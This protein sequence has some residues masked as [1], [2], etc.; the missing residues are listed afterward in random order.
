MNVKTLDSAPLMVFG[1]FSVMGC[2]IAL[3]DTIHS[4]SE[5]KFKFKFNDTFYQ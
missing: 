5:F 3:W 1:C 2:C 4:S